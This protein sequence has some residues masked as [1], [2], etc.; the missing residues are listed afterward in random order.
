MLLM[1]ACVTALRTVKKKKTSLLNECLLLKRETYISQKPLAT[2]QKRSEGRGPKSSG[3]ADR[4]ALDTE[5][6][7][8]AWSW[9]T[10]GGKR[11][12]KF[13]Q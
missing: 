3:L 11:S 12:E 6:Q 5:G 13:R 1:A 2:G 7:K 8:S 9:P 4:D 10:V